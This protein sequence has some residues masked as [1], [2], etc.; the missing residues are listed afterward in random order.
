[1]AVQEE[2]TGS[3][4]FK[5]DRYKVVR[6]ELKQ[7][8]PARVIRERDMPSINVSSGGGFKGLEPGIYHARCDLI[9]DL[10]VRETQ[11]GDKHKVYIRFTVPDQVVEKEDGE[12]FQMSIGTQITASLGKKANLRKMLEAW[13]GKPFTDEELK[14]F[15][16]TKLLNAPATL[17]VSTY[18][19]DGEPKPKIENVLRCKQEVGALLRAPVSYSVESTD[20]ELADAPP[21]IREII[22][23][24]RAAAGN[25]QQNQ[26]AAHQAD[27]DEGYAGDDGIPF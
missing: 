7:T 27:E 6:Q 25:E 2:Y 23:E 17:V 19:A 3:D 26:A 1:M 5:R 11:Y 22:E 15:D 21:W 18:M 8:M 10:G 13:R 4:G 12:K 16:L 14:G 9:A 24:Q 20:A